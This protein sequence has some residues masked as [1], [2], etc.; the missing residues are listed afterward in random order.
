MLLPAKGPS[1]YKLQKITITELLKKLIFVKKL[2]FNP[3]KIIAIRSLFYYF[4]IV[5]FKRL[6]N[7]NNKFGHLEIRS[8][9]SYAK[10]RRGPD[11]TPLERNSK[12]V[13]Q[14]G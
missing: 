2:S 14:G 13:Y 1:G 4:A 11:C 9:F 7:Q 12:E 5:F 10:L 6:S 3:V 8:N